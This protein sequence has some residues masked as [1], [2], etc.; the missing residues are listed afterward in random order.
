MLAL[1]NSDIEVITPGW[2]EELVALAL[3]PGTGAV[4]ACLW[5]P[6]DTL[7]HGGVVLGIKGVAAHAPRRLRRD[8][9]QA[10]PRVFCRRTV[11]AVTGACLVVRR[12]RY[13]QAG[14]LNAEA[15]AVAFNDIDFCLRLKQ[16]GCR[17]LWTPVAALY[18]AGG[19]AS[20]YRVMPRGWGAFAVEGR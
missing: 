5:Y 1:L 17:N 12:E 6:D 14:G 19:K 18:H 13:A 9:R 8:E 20:N 16:A 11:S 4:G 3:L 10:H 7:Q 15:L 2:L